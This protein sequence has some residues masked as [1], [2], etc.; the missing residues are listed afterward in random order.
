M[1]QGVIARSKQKDQPSSTSVIARSEA[2][3]QSVPA[4]D[5]KHRP[6]PEGAEGERIATACGLAMTLLFKNA[7]FDSLHFY[8]QYSSRENQVTTFSPY[9]KVRPSSSIRGRM[10]MPWLST[11]GCIRSGNRQGRP[12]RYAHRS[13]SAQLSVDRT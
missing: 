9:W 3:W 1:N 2:T 5:A 10:L 12:S 11:Q 8:R 13:H 6:L 7:V 4:C